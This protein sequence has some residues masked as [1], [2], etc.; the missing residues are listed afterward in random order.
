M[1][2]TGEVVG[3]TLTL[4]PSCAG[5]PAGRVSARDGVPVPGEGRR[6]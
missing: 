2:Y 1:S 5:G 4:T 3:D 6:H